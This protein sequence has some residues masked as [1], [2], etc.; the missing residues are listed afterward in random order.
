M[1][2]KTVKELKEELAKYPDDYICYPWSGGYFYMDKSERPAEKPKI[3]TYD[4]DPYSARALILKLEMEYDVSIRVYDS[5]RYCQI[6]IDKEEKE[7][8]RD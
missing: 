1:E 7:N 8:E 2:M 3:A 5:K 4:T 6:C